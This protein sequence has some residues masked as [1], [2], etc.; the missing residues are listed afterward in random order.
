MLHTF[1]EKTPNNVAIF[2][3]G[4]LPIQIYKEK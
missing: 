4:H 3:P 2:K 1:R